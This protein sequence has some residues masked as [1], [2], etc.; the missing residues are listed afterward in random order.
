MKRSSLSLLVLGALASGCGHYSLEARFAEDRLLA[1][2]PASY[3]DDAAVSLYAEDGVLLT[4]R[5]GGKSFTQKL[6]HRA[7][8]IQSEK[9]FDLAEVRIPMRADATLV[10]L[11]AR[12]K[13]PDGTVVELLPQQIISDETSGN[14]EKGVAG[15]LF[16]FAD[17]QRGSV[18]EY[19]YVIEMPFLDTDEESNSF[20]EYAVRHYEAW[21]ES[22]KEIILEG[23]FYNVPAT[24]TATV[25]HDEAFRRIGVSADNLSGKPKNEE[26]APDWTFTQPRWAYRMLHWNINGHVTPM[27]ET[28][29][30]VIGRWARRAWSLDKEPLFDGFDER[31]DVS[32]CDNAACKVERALALLDKHT[33]YSG[34]GTMRSAR[35]AT[36]VWQSKEASAFER[37][38]LLRWL[39]AR[40]GVDASLAVY[41]ARFT[42]QVD[43]QFPQTER[44][45][46]ILVTV[47]G[48]AGPLWVDPGCR[49]CGAGQVT[50]EAGAANALVFHVTER[51]LQEPEI[52]SEWRTVDAKTL[53]APE[54]IM[55]HEATVWPNGEVTLESRNER[56]GRFALDRCVALRNDTD[57]S[58]LSR[59]RDQALKLSP[60]ARAASASAATCNV[61]AATSSEPRKLTLPQHAIFDGDRLEVPLTLL[62]PDYV[63]LF[64]EPKRLQ[65]IVNASSDWHVEQRLHLK[66]PPGYKLVAPLQEKAD[67]P[68]F[69]AAFVVAPA[70]DGA[71][72]RL[73]LDHAVGLYDEDEYA[74][75][76]K[77]GDFLRGARMRM[78]ELVKR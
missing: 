39:L 4:W 66:T 68:G 2:D 32:G 53:P 74:A 17:V 62:D 33:E 51:P 7:W 9:A 58:R 10:A 21:I 49:A 50:D 13:K 5:K 27:L 18:L 22:S 23:R 19:S 48:P 37:A 56:R 31:V 42:G 1:Y 73:S 61:A 26:Y 16:R 76:R 55:R 41:T 47:A 36:E 77:L 72:V 65:P 8:A 29:N 40:A 59:A 35:K 24:P 3:P 15:R 25:G 54:R 34:L 78:V 63:K 44:F 64:A 75:Y 69:K 67:A 46:R 52:T 57:S 60:A 6:T 71:D 30:D 12:N 45:N 14:P 28:W 43:P 70:P 20:G 11:R 38:L